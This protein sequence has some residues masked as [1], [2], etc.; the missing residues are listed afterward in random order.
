[1]NPTLPMVS[2][3][4][5]TRDGA[6]FL[7]EQLRSI[8]GQTYPHWDIILSDDGSRDD[9]VS[10]A[11]DCIP[12]VQLRIFDGPQRGLAQNF[13]H[14]LMQVP[15]GHFVA[16]CDQD[17]VWRPD[18]LERALAFLRGARGPSIYSAGRFITDAKL[19]VKRVQPRSSALGLPGTLFRNRIAGHTCVL[20][21]DAVHL[22]QRF[23]PSD[24]VP[25]HDWWAAIVLRAHGATFIHDPAPV[26]YYRQHN[27][28]VIGADGGRM[29]CVLSGQYVAWVRANQLALL[30][31]QDQLP[32]TA[33]VALRICLPLQAR[34]SRRS[35]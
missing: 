35:K 25:F 16:F 19:N 29:R 33:K 7:A 11:R 27:K 34:L 3:V 22:L 32:L 17:D 8:S 14:G 31:F 2:I 24:A 28:N 20:S 13:W 9:T 5:A 12:T 1:M 10:I 4:L 26:L 18:K 15:A 23:A 6:M 30:Q 21:P